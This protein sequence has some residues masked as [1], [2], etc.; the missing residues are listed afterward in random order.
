M[1]LLHFTRPYLF[2]YTIINVM[3][4][5]SAVASA[6]GIDAHTPFSP[7]K[8]GRRIIAIHSITNVLVIEIIADIFPLLS[9]VKRPEAKIFIP[10]SR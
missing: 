8:N 3:E 5:I 2:E 9:A 10:Q 7:N 6:T 4:I 1:F